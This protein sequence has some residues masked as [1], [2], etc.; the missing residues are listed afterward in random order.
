[1]TRT[2]LLLLALL[3]VAGCRDDAPPAAPASAPATPSSAAPATAATDPIEAAI[4]ATDRSA[5]DR[6][7]DAGRQPAS[8]LTFIGVAPGMR[9]AELMAGGGYTAELLARVVGDE[10]RVY[11]QNPPVI[12]ERFAEKPWSE[13]LAK[14]VNARVVR[15]DSALDDPLP[16]EARDLDVVLSNLVY[17]DFVWMGVDRAKMNAAIFAALRPGGLYY[18]ADHT[19]AD[20][21]GITVVET[22]HRI[23]PGV[24][25]E[26][27]EAAGFVLVR[28]GDFLRHPEDTRDWSTSPRTAGEKRGTSDR[29]VLLFQKPAGDAATA[30]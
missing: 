13:R 10:G 8:M 16:P 23:E 20:G 11:G 6:A 24:I 12:L 15:V 17:H 25:R 27:V 2:S 29:F 4:A 5:D 1:M 26:E 21:A 14:P 28:E 18:V 9:V 22:L 30:R 19:A 3:A 7:L